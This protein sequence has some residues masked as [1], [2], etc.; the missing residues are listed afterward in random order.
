MN[1]DERACIIALDVGGSSIKS[2]L[3]AAGPKI[4][5]AVSVDPIDSQ[6]SAAEIFETFSTII[7]GHLENCRA[8][9]GI[10][11]AFPGP[12][13]Y[14]E[15]ICLIQGQEKYDAL[16]GLNLS[17]KLKELLGAPN[18][19]IRYRNDAEAAILG[20]ALYGGGAGFSRLL[21]LTIG[22]G[23][24][25]AFV[26]DGI[27]VTEGAGV[28]DHGWLYAQPFG[29]QRADDV[30]ST[31][32]LLARLREHGI[33]AKD[34]A[35]VIS[36]ADQQDQALAEVFASFGSD[37]GR[38]LKPFVSNFRADAVLVAGGIA[39][40]WD[41]FTPALEQSLPVPVVKGTLGKRAALLG[42]ATLYF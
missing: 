16:Y 14:E 3:V 18:L 35:S 1:S 12:F 10:V 31:R 38:F 26:A 20:E 11:M 9:R 22:T 2:A 42:A 28:P 40:G 21:G 24:G 17:Q 30:F 41:W 4:V 8:A 19:Q 5:G 33:Q 23:L 36:M 39:E 13:D 34:I 37:L 29:A 27:I 7:T 6:G 32:G 15:G 25:S